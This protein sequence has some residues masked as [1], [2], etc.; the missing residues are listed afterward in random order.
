MSYVTPWVLQLN[1]CGDCQAYTYTFLNFEF[2]ND[3]K[4]WLTT[5]EAAPLF[6][7]DLTKPGAKAAFLQFAQREGIPFYRLSERRWRW[8]Q[9]ELEDWLEGRR[10]GGVNR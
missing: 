2:M 1:Y 5:Q 9:L 7:Y 6:D 3:Q 8:N 4:T 10:V